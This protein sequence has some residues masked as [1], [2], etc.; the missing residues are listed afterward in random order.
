ML[1]CFNVYV[2]LFVCVVV[3]HITIVAIR[4]GFWKKLWPLVI[5]CVLRTAGSSPV[6][7]YADPLTSLELLIYYLTLTMS[8]DRF[9]YQVSLNALGPWLFKVVSLSL[10]R[11]FMDSLSLFGN[12]LLADMRNLSVGLK[13]RFI[14]ISEVRRNIIKINGKSLSWLSNRQNLSI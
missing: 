3:Y 10:C 8:S 1:F 9:R 2:R 11:C 4:H 6:P 7:N 14:C 12:E 5:G 13:Y